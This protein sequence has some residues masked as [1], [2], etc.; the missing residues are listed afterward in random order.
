MEIA[1]TKNFTISSVDGY[2]AEVLDIY[3]GSDQEVNI[4]VLIK[5]GSGKLTFIT[6]LPDP[7]NPDTSTRNNVSSGI[8]FKIFTDTV[9]SAKLGY[10]SDYRYRIQ[11]INSGQL[12]ITNA[13]A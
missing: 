4:T 2:A 12:V 7:D 5:T 8:G 10:A 1:S 13:Q 3:T 11:Y 9:L 6:P